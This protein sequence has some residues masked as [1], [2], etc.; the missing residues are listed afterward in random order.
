MTTRQSASVPPIAALTMPEQ[1]VIIH[2]EQSK[3]CVAIPRRAPSRER[4]RVQ[5]S[6]A[7]HPDLPN[8]PATA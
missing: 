8:P 7:G 6:F 3:T 5:E 2:D 1:G 4:K